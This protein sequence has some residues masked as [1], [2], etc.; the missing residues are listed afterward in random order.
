MA[1]KKIKVLF[2]RR[3]ERDLGEIY[4][5]LQKHSL[6]A[7]EKVDAAIFRAIRQ[8]ETFPLA[9]HWVKE[10]SGKKYREIHVFHFRIIYR[11][12]A[13]P[14]KVQILAIYHGK[15]LLPAMDD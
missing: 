12:L 15:R 5:Y 14:R 7:L 9:G 3:A 4:E 13:E 10:F 8:L 6:Q 2:T 11:F 1:A